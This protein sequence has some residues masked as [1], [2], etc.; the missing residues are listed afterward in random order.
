M[1]DIEIAEKAKV[2]NITEVAAGI[3]SLQ[4]ILTIWENIR[5]GA[6]RCHRQA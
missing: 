6:V 2:K 5:K 4:R 3:D 1:N